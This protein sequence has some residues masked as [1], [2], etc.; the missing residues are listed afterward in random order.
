MHVSRTLGCAFKH[1]SE[2]AVLL[3][4]NALRQGPVD[5]TCKGWFISVQQLNVF[6]L[7]PLYTM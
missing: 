1:Q 7:R 5:A 3:E 6:S 2:N 4:G